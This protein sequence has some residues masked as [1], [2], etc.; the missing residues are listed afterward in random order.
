MI[1]A[2]P[3]RLKYRL[4][5][6][7]VGNSGMKASLETNERYLSLTGIAFEYD[8]VGHV[9][10]PE[11]EEL[12]RCYFGNHPDEPVVLHRKEMMQKL[13][14]FHCLK[15]PDVEGTFNNDLLIKLKAWD[16]TAFTVVIDKLEHQRRYA[17]WRYDP[18]H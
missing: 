1:V 2:K 18:Y 14:P 10:S 5:I 6:D 11:L 15:D 12:K 8:Y 16:Y 13:W 17:V 7:E 4:Y 3:K 9:L